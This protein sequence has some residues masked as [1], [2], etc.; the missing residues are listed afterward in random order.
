MLDCLELQKI[1]AIKIIKDNK[2]IRHPRIYV[3]GIGGGRRH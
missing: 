3:S 2:I 1:S